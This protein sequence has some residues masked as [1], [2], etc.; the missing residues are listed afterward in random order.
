[1]RNVILILALIL[2]TACGTDTKSD[3]I[4]MNATLPA[5]FDGTYIQSS[6][7]ILG[8]GRCSTIWTPKVAYETVDGKVVIQGTQEK[9]GVYSFEYDR[10]NGVKEITTVALTDTSVSVNLTCEGI[11]S[12]EH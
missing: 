5:T 11:K 9:D 3:H 2:V 1:M 12:E 7:V 6:G 10:E 8:N 4:P